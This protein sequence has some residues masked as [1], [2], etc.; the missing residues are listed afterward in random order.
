MMKKTTKTIN[1]TEADEYLSGTP[2]NDA[3]YG[4]NGSDTLHGGT[5]NDLL[6]GGYN[7]KAGDSIA[8]IGDFADYKDSTKAVIVDLEFGIALGGGG[9]DI[10]VNIEGVW[11]SDF[12]DVLIGNNIGNELWGFED[13]DVLH[14][15]DGPDS[16][17]G[18][19]GDDFLDG[20]GNMTMT[21]FDSFYAIC[22]TVFYSDS[23]SEVEVNLQS[24]TATGGNGNDTLINFEGVWGSNFN[25]VITGDDN[26]NGL[27]GSSGSDSL[28]GA[29]GDDLLNGGPGDDY[30]DGGINVDSKGHVTSGYDVADYYES[31][32]AVVVNLQSH[33]AS[34]DGNDILVN[35]EGVWGSGFNDSLTGSTGNDILQGNAGNDSIQGGR[36]DDSLNAGFGSDYLD[37]GSGNDVLSDSYDWG[38]ILSGG[39]GAD[40][41]QFQ[42]NYSPDNTVTS[43]INDFSRKQKDK[44]DLSL[45]DTT[46][47]GETPNF[48]AGETFSGDFSLSVPHQYYFDKAAQTLYGNTDY[49]AAADIEI[50][51]TGVN[52]LAATDIIF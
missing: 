1:G 12:G 23:P 27:R 11:G 21:S 47:G 30:L 52:K 50:H 32:N 46:N 36:G 5:G 48:K 41:F 8:Q 17:Y 24:G 45:I 20:G 49:D 39:T 35:I 42:A 26:I 16:I 51:L 7:G 34:G 31:P 19:A 28:Y 9:N 38:G 29:G 6:D 18:G 10:L 3:I 22:D 37:G 44:I 43:V 2:N 13:S 14:G 33:T 4:G 15:G 25:D 40:I